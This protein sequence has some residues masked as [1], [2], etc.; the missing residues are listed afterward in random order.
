MSLYLLLKDAD[1]C[2]GAHFIVLLKG[3][4]YSR[5]RDDVQSTRNKNFIEA[6]RD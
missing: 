5:R 1:G 3:Y 6:V 4:I 2:F